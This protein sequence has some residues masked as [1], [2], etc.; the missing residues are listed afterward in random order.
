MA[1]KDNFEIKRKKIIKGLEETYR[2]LVES[3][4]KTNSP[5]VITRNGKVVEVSPFD[6][7]PT[8]K[9]NCEPVKTEKRK[10]S[11]P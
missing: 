4:K 8:V 9:Y 3:K 6:M 2:R 11:K 10:R 7:P 5:F 1:G